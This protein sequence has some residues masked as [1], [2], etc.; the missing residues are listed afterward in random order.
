MKTRLLIVL[1]VLAL[2]AAA[3]APGAPEGE[4]PAEGEA[5]QLEIFSWWTGAGEEAGLL[6]LI[7][8][9][10]EN[11]PNVEVINAAVAGGAGTNAKA[12]LAS[13]MQAGDPPDTFQ[14]HA[15]EEIL[16]TWVEAGRMEALNDLYQEEGW[17]G[18][19]P[20][21]L[22]A[23]VSRDGDI[24]SVPVNIHR[25][26]V[27]WTNPAI[28]E[29]QG[30]EPPVTIE[31]FFTVAEQLETAGVTP[32]ALG[33]KEPWALLHLWESVLLA[34]AGPEGYQAVFNGETGF[35]SPEV[36]ESLEVLAEMFQFVNDDHAARNWQDAAQLVG[37]G[38]AAMHVMGDWAAGYFTVDLELE[39]VTGFGWAAAPGTGGNFLIVS[40]TFGLPT[41]APHPQPTL[42]WLRL[43]GS[44]EGQDTFNPL[45]GSIPARLDA[46]P[47]AYN[48]YGQSALDDFSQDTLVPSLAHGSAA[49]P[50]FLDGA[51]QVM[52]VFASNQDVDQ[53]VQG[54]VAAAEQNPLGG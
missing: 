10:K 13:R 26:N 8:L 11:H 49:N 32:L 41:G 27:L 22:V 25:A 51:L 34:T 18:M 38:D 4:A 17:Q 30:I 36:R 31:D 53:A 35:D 9:Y 7:E 23:M 46:D 43:L 12:V 40:D 15:G 48:A 37:N 54:L 50:G 45:K 19:F 6:A 14:V 28:F 47:G 16:A 33:D 44:V 2:L 42:D 3:C 21:Q 39:P 5:T 52:S 20:E 29:E 24:Y 1:G